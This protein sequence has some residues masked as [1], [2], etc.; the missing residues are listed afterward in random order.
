MRTRRISM[1]IFT[2]EEK[3]KLM[4]ERLERI[5]TTPMAFQLGIYVGDRIVNKYLPTL[6]VDML[7]T[8]NIITV[9]EEDTEKYNIVDRA[10]FNKALSSDKDKTSNKAEWDALVSFR[11]ILKAKY[12]PAILVC[13]IPIL[14][15]S[16]RDMVDF[17]KGIAASL[18][19]CD[20]CYYNTDVDRIKIYNDEDLIFS[21]IELQL[22]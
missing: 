22:G 5:T 1:P 18:W 11:N 7:K 3:Q 2:P 17:K 20:C 15:V 13:Y 14:N 16:E 21:I 12:L 19:D 6:S 8:N 10:Y 9:S 4:A